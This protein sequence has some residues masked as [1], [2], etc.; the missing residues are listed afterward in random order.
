M[1]APNIFNAALLSSVSVETGSISGAVAATSFT[2]PAAGSTIIIPPTAVEAGDIELEVTSSNGGDLCTLTLHDN[3]NS[4]SVPIPIARSYDG[5]DWEITAGPYSDALSQPDCV[6]SVCTFSDLPPLN[7]DDEY[8]FS[9]VLTSYYRDADDIGAQAEAARF[10]EQA[11]F[12]PS[13]DTIEALANSGPDKYF[14]WVKDQIENK[15]MNS[16]R[17]YF[18]RYINP[19]MEYPGYVAAPGPRSACDRT[20][21]WRMFALDKRDGVRSSQS[22][23]AKY[24]SIKKVGDRFGWFVEGMLR[25][26][27]ATMPK[28]YSEEGEYLEDLVLFPTL[29]LLH[30]REYER[31]SCIG[32]P[33]YVYQQPSS[34][35]IR[36]GFV[37]NPKVDLTGVE[38][39][40]NLVPY[41]IVDLPPIL[42]N[43]EAMISVNNDEFET[44]VYFSQYNAADDEFFLD[45]ANSINRSQCNNHP[46][47]HIA[48]YEV[49][50][51][52]D[53]SNNPEVGDNN[54]PETVFPPIFGK[55]YNERTQ[56]FEHVLF[57]PKLM[58][59][60]NTPENPIAD[61]GGFMEY[62]SKG[63]TYCANAPRNFRNEDG[64]KYCTSFNTHTY[65]HAIVII[66]LTNLSHLRPAPFT[67]N[68]T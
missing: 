5:L 44:N 31:K 3:N 48:A 12:G 55:T 6:A 54:H 26:T 56:Q 66:V 42:G 11:T 30:F 49:P 57:D 14:D 59:Q 16:H 47:T 10:L 4:A 38:N 68:F 41:S 43:D 19:R 62:D 22:R 63:R 65:T 1:R 60:E 36:R 58:L 15:P 20:S 18:R 50:S 8:D 21:H 67:L 64:C 29:Y 39:N 25:T 40:S 2:C 28:L 35:S 46:N 33:V 37:L 34:N 53:V 24:L 32:C 61:G 52:L 7:D 13:R 9:Y 27:T 51:K 45:D 23:V 17:E